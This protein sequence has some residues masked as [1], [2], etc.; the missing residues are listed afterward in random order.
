MSARTPNASPDK[1]RHARGFSFLD[2]ATQSL[3]ATRADAA[4]LGVVL[5]ALIVAALLALRHRAAYVDELNHYAQIE[6]FLRGEFRVFTQY[7][8]T[9]PGY[10]A[11]VAAILK[12]TGGESLDA[13]R[14]VNA[15]FALIG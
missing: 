1:P 5:G 15:A 10:H 11:I 4:I 3:K 13:A 9:I 14:L 12:I 7:L 6:L 8:T 2:R